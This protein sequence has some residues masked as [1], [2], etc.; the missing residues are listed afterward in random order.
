MHN[1][2]EQCEN[3]VPCNGVFVIILFE[4]MY[5]KKKNLDWFFVIS[6]VIKVE[7]HESVIEAEEIMLIIR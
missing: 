7:V 5:V 2:Q 4:T 6:G 1:F 3:C